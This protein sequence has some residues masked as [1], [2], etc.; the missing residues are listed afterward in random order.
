M[1]DEQWGHLDYILASASLLPQ[2]T[3]ATDW[4]INAD[5][6][7]VLDYNTEFQSPAQQALFH[8]TAFYRTSDHDPVLV[9][10]DLATDPLIFRDGFET[11]DQPPR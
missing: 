3:G 8:G 2:V 11:P 4:H 10:L 7:I 6:P 1:F 9:G 5:E